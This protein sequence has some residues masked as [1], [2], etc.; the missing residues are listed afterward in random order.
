MRCSR[1]KNL[2]IFQSTLRARRSDLLMVCQNHRLLIS[3]HAPRKAERRP[4]IR[5]GRF[6][7]SFQSTL[8][9]R[10][11]D[12]NCTRFDFAFDIS[13]HAPRK[14]E[15]QEKAERMKQIFQFQSTLR[16]RRSDGI[17][18][19]TLNFWRYF[20]PRSAQG[21]ATLQAAR[22]YRKHIISIHAPRKAERLVGLCS[23]ILALGISIHAPRKAERRFGFVTCVGS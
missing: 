20:N 18:L 3:I 19:I 13:I 14:A 4:T 16:A 1:C 21:G 5:G 8:R 9:A 2:N 7:S 12:T 15:R 22:S 11:S 6:L 10:R 23:N 17:G